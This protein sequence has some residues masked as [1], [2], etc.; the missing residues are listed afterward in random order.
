MSAVEIRSYE[1]DGGDLAALVQRAWKQ[2]FQGQKWFP[3]WDQ[4]YFAWRVLDPRLGS[5]DLCVAAYEG[6]SLIGCIMA[7]AAEFQWGDQRVRGSYSSWLS[8]DQESQS[9]GVALRLVDEL[10]L[11]H[12]QQGLRFSIGCTRID[13]QSPAR[14]FWDSLARRR[15]D[16]FRFWGPIRL[17]AHVLNPVRVAAAGLTTWERWGPQLLRLIP[18]WPTRAKRPS[19]IRPFRADDTAECLRLLEIQ[20]RTTDF[21]MRWNSDRLEHQLDHGQFP[22]TFVSHDGTSLHGFLNYYA[23]TWSGE[24]DL[25]VAM[26]D[27][28]AGDQWWPQ[29][30]LLKAAEAQM[31]DD[32]VDLVLMMASAAAPA[33]VLLSR[34][35]VPIDA[36]VEL[37]SLFVDPQLNCPPPKSFHILFT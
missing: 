16:E 2:N 35:F 31:R 17:W 4:K 7:E 29:R 25:R 26:I 37:F 9:R 12:Q 3:L 27:L 5:R 32:G 18:R 23:L 20:N 15:P 8:V 30:S 1:G 6:D 24:Q 14:K 21:Q 19:G 33:S 34:G 28:L 36:E 22:R 11:R 13:H 10:R